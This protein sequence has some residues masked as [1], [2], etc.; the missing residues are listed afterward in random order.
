[1]PRELTNLEVSD[2]LGRHPDVQQSVISNGPL[3]DQIFYPSAGVAVLDPS[4]RYVLVWSDASNRMHF[5]DLADMTQM[6][7]IAASTNAPAY[8]SDPDYLGIIHDALR[9]ML[10]VGVDMG[11][12]LLLG[13]GAILA[14]KYL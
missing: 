11:S 14:A 4:G 6:A 10:T 2:F 3:T 12:L 7:A 8:V 9:G 1:M 13:V 5:V